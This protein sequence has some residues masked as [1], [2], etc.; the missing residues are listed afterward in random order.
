MRLTKKQPSKQLSKHKSS[1]KQINLKIYKNLNNYDKTYIITDDINI[2]DRDINFTPL[3]NILEHKYGLTEDTGNVDS[4]KD[5]YLTKPLFI[6]FKDSMIDIS[7]KN[8]FK[9]LYNIP[10][11]IFNSLSGIN[12]IAYKNLLYFNM[13]K[14]NKEFTNKHMAKTVY[15]K[16]DTKFQ[17]GNGVYIARPIEILHGNLIERSGLNII[18]YD[19]YKGFFKAKE[20]LKIYKNVII[21]NYI[22]KPLLFNG[23]KFHFRTYF[24]PSI[25]N[26]HFKVYYLDICRIYTAKLPYREK[27]YYNADIHDTHLKSTKADFFFTKSKYYFRQNNIDIFHNDLNKQNIGIEI[28][29]NNI[30]QQIEEIL[31]NISIILSKDVSI[32][33]NNKNGY[34]IF[35]ADYMITQEQQVILLEVNHQTGIN[36]RNKTI[37]L[38]FDKHLFKLID[39]TIIEPSITGK[40]KKSD[41]SYPCVFE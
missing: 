39:E 35:S 31:H 41:Y 2:K 11:L 32:Y 40:F 5:I 36:F 3:K 27:D 23:L 12:N 4:K 13:M 26:G 28:N 22:L 38:E 15:L 24:I 16:P 37:K 9:T 18:I 1:R 20:L 6:F 34:Y 19:D 14:L 29:Y 25:V 21:S 33:D 8:K 7:R 10:T 30:W 17:S